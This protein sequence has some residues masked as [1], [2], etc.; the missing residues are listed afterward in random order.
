M[1]RLLIPE[2][3]VT[4][5]DS[6]YV[7]QDGS[8]IHVVAF[9]P[10]YNHSFSVELGFHYAFLPAFFHERKKPIAEYRFLDCGLSA[11]P[12]TFR[13]EDRIRSI[14]YGSDREELRRILA[15]SAGDALRVFD[16]YR[17]PWR[18]CDWWLDEFIHGEP[19]TSDRIAP[20]RS[21]HLPL[22]LAVMAMHLGQTGIAMAE[23]EKMSEGKSQH[24]RELYRNHILAGA[25]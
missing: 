11:R 4:G 2:G 9:Q 10:H 23:L 18:D 25:G 3:F 16:R 22:F 24:V 15:E 8:Q 7:R 21:T 14:P 20:W 5:K 13:G 6:A 19:N 1:K 12:E 17:D